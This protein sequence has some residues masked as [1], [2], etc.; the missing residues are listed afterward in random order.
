MN[1]VMQPA[2]HRL[3]V[4]DQALADMMPGCLVLAVSNPPQMI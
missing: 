3:G 1:L 4:H 2:Q